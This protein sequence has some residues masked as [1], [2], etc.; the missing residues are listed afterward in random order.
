MR[1]SE[2]WQNC[3]CQSKLIEEMVFSCELDRAVGVEGSA[4]LS[5]WEGREEPFRSP[6]PEPISRISAALHGSSELG[7]ILVKIQQNWYILMTEN[8]RAHNQKGLVSAESSKDLFLSVLVL[9][10]CSSHWF[11]IPKEPC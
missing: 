7:F 5:G 11:L 6:C 10:F 4:G 3:A 2:L 1:I 8:G 9:V